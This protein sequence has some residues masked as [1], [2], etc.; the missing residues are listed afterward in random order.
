MCRRT[1]WSQNSAPGAIAIAHDELIPPASGL[2]ALSKRCPRPSTRSLGLAHLQSCRMDEA[3]L[4]FTEIVEQLQ[5]N[6]HSMPNGIDRGELPAVRPRRRRV[7]VHAAELERFITDSSSGRHP[8]EATE[9]P[10]LETALTSVPSKIEPGAV[11]RAAKHRGAARDEPLGGSRLPLLSVTGAQQR[12]VRKARVGVVMRVLRS[13]VR[14]QD[15]RGAW[16]EAA[17]SAAPATARRHT[18]GWHC[19]VAITVAILLCA[20]AVAGCG[21]PNGESA[22][23]IVENELAQLQQDY[24]GFPQI[25]TQTAN[26]LEAIGSSYTADVNSLVNNL[27]TQISDFS[28]CTADFFGQRAAEGLAQILHEIDSK[29]PAP[30]PIPHVCRTDPL[31]SITTATTHEVVFYG[32]LQSIPGAVSVPRGDRIRRRHCDKLDARI[33]CDQFQL[34]TDL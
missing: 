8:E 20:F 31:A 11:R 23:Q 13:S 33:H 16:A 29:K 24:D 7:R 14:G 34:R 18:H 3:S 12:S 19:G 5:V 32:Q 25:L 21:H 15:R 1:G 6:Q 26:Q 17:T 28:Y 27:N 22:E 2:T 10:E 4:T 9:R 30:D